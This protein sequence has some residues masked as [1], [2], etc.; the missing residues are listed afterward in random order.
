MANPLGFEPL[1]QA[2]HAQLDLLPDARR[3][4][5]TQ[6]SIKDAALAAFAVFFTQ[7]PSFLAHQRALRHTKGRSNAETLFGISHI[8]CDNQIRNLL[9]PVPPDALFPIFSSLSHALTTAGVVA[10][11]RAFDNTL[12][13]ALDGTQYFSS[14][15][16]T[17]PACSKKTAASGTSTF[18]HCMITPVI[19]APGKSEVLSLQPEFITPQDGHEKQDCEQEA[20][21]RWVRTQAPML[22]F[23]NITVL[24]DDLFCHYPFCSLLREHGWNFILVCKPD[25]HP[26]LYSWIDYLSRVEQLGEVKKR[27]WNGKFGELWTYHFASSVPLRGEQPTLLVNWCELTIRHEKSGKQLYH[28]AFATMHAVTDETVEDVV[29]AGRA[30]WKVENENNNVLKP[31]GYHLEHNF[32]HGKENLAAVLVTLNLLAFLFHTVFELLDAKYRMLRATL[33]ARETFFGDLRTLTRYFVFESWEHLLTFMIEQLELR[34]PLNT[35]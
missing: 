8:P 32:G 35:S 14:Q 30:R 18:S 7:S 11:F 5:N 16:I 4:K 3:G 33:G 29:A 23:S 26:K 24:G 27:H 2:L 1:V 21:K 19:V 20:A 25:S 9:D 34:P 13:I 10:T 31:K 6:F 22:P 12:L 17:C 15:H 28:T